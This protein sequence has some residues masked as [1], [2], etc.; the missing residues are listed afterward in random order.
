MSQP[1]F[2]ELLAAARRGDERAWAYLYDDV[3]PIVLAYLRG[4]RAPDPED[5]AGEVLLQV[6][7]DLD[8]F[9]GDRHRFRS[10]VLAIAHHRL[11][12]ARRYRSRRPSVP[13]EP[14]AIGP[15]EA[16]DDPAAEAASTEDLDRLL[17]QLE[18]LTEEQRE[19]IL[20]R[21]VA[22]LSVREVAQILGKRPGAV[23]AMQHRGI[24]ALRTATNRRPAPST[25]RHVSRGGRTDVAPARGDA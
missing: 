18:V 3:A 4:Q 7:R 17:E 15:V 16:P 14:A 9:T 10:W 11:I 12:D 5:L 19:V 20:L 6:V 1:A 2:H 22:D 8:R 13:M 23:K 24:T 21:L 25:P